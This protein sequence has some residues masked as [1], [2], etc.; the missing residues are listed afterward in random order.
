MADWR[1]DAVL[2]APFSPCRGRLV[3]VDGHCGAHARG[4]RLAAI[5]LQGDD[6]GDA[7]AD[8]GEVAAG[9]VL[10][11]QQREL[12]G[13]G[14][15]DLLD[16]AAE[17][18][19]GVGIDGDVHLLARRDV[20]DR[21]LVDVG[22]HVDAAQVG[23]LQKGQ[24]GGYGLALDGVYL[25]DL[26]A[27]GAGDRDSGGGLAGAGGGGGDGAQG[28][29]FGDGVAQFDVEGGERASGGRVDVDDLAVQLGVIGAV[30]YVVVVEVV[31][32]AAADGE[33]G[34]DDQQR[35]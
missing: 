31:R 35:D 14:R 21:A 5:A 16:V 18:G 17:A 26:A 19:A 9:V 12:A 1:G 29:T 13:G 27:D 23:Y 24:A 6:D 34:D 15:H 22:D 4:E 2:L 3:E 28:L 8:L 32:D 10:G 30:V 11:G 25:D 20:I 7:L 33:H